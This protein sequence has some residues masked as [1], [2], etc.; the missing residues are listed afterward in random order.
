MVRQEGQGDRQ[1]WTSMEPLH[2]AASQTLL[3]ANLHGA[4]LTGSH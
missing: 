4:M 1:Q 2:L 3:V